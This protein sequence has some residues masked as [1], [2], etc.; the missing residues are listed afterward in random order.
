MM[1][2]VIIVILLAYATAE[3]AT[4]EEAQKETKEEQF[5]Y[6]KPE[7]GD[8]AH[9]LAESFHNLEDFKQSWVLSEA[10]KDGVDE[11]ISKYDGKW[12][13]DEPKENA[14]GGDL[15]LVLKSEAKHA[16][17]SAKLSSTFNFNDQPLIIQ[18]EVKFQKAQE[19]GG[20]YIKLLADKEGLS[21]EEFG[22]TTLYSIMFGPDKCGHDS[23]MHFILQHENPISGKM[24]EHHAKPPSGDFKTMFDDKKTHLVTLVVRPGNTFDILLDKKNYQ[25][26]KPAERHDTS[27]QPGEGDR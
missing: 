13:V 2:K 9:N 1:F 10:K 26:R 18:Y 24:V 25:L 27:N 20:A 16:A 14:L 5:K 7:I 15:A 4:V 3:E 19:C 21:L 17:I 11:T 6:V 8:L 12:L 22:D 23:K